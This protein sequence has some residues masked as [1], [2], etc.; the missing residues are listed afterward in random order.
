MVGADGL[1]I[2]RMNR[3]TNIFRA[4]SLL[5]LLG[6]GSCVSTD[7]NDVVDTGWIEPS[8]IL[9][10]QITDEA[11]RMP[12][13]HGF[14]RLEQI[15]WFASVGE[16]AY[17]TLLEMAIDPRDDVAAAAL[18]ALGATMDRRLVAA[19][20]ELPWPESRRRTDL[21]L[22]RA[23]T[24]VRLGDWSELATLIG[25][26]RDTRLYTRSLCLDALRE[27]THETLGFDPRAGEEDRERAVERWE[28][29]WLARSGDTLL[30]G[31]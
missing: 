18:A 19:I 15:R 8:P 2:D 9:R 17:P 21:A 1:G 22:E 31:S 3:R 10:Q 6:A 16:P 13:T 28:Q 20:Q 7:A 4:A 27:A 14:E 29:W 11:Q 26:L 12:W 23:R 25:G 30:T 5:L 24:L